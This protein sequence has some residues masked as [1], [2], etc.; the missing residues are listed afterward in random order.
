[1]T[2]VEWFVRGLQKRGVQWV[3]TLCGHGLDPF[4][5]ACKQRG[6]RLIDTRNEQAAAYM[7]EAHG[8][9][10]K[11]PGVV[12]VSSA[13][14]HANA[15]TGVVDACLDQAPMLL[16][17][18]AAA[19]RTSGL[20]HFQDI[21]QVALAKP[22]TKYSRLIDR[23]ERVLQILDEALRIAAEPPC[24]PVH[25]TFPMDMQQTEVSEERMIRPTREPVHSVAAVADFESAAACLSSSTEPLIIAGSGIYYA[26]EEQALC[27][28][29]REFSVPVLVP[30]WDRGMID[31]PL[32]SFV[33]V[34]GA[35]TGGRA[36]LSAADCIVMAGAQPDYRVGYLQAGAIREDAKVIR[37][38]RGWRDFAAAY[39]NAGGE[40]H[41]KWLTE[42]RRRR[43]AYQ[44]RVEKTG[45]EQAR[46]KMHAV[47]VA[48]A[49]TKVLPDDGM[50]LVDGGSIGQWFH[51][52]LPDRYPGYWLTCGRGG[53]V[54]WGLGGAMAARA[55]YPDR[56]LV[57]VSGDGSFTF[58]VAEIE[59]AVRQGLGFVAVVAD[60]ESWG[61]TEQGHLKQFGE[62]ITSKL[63]P[64]DFAKLAE[65]L[66][67]KGVRANS[68]D[69]L[70][71]ALQKGLADTGVTIIHTRITGGN[72]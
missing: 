37:V 1:M 42:V 60:D 24:G 3:A 71:Q 49:V 55:T 56:P 43:A 72:P 57:L 67:A 65:A 14:A 27:E 16:L 29:A 28:F 53:V 35:A 18:G 39:R 19:L 41:K 66:G 7:A 8:R 20:G 21:D 26:N 33:G 34:V 17:S 40:S 45:E 31:H 61:I 62:A 46:G 70:E 25:I 51:Q 6:L 64:I 36:A 4:D 68:P 22:A 10:T 58:N 2:A 30:I 11:R 38:D 69:E 63:G 50:L 52:M 32:E 15:M 44:A 5:E 13:V 9:L 59:C 47:H 23:P 54:G 48:R 12:A